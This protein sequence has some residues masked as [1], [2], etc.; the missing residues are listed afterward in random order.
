MLTSHGT[1]RFSRLAV[2]A[3][4]LAGLGLA[5]AAALA[6]GAMEKPLSRIYMCYKEDPEKL[7]GSYDGVP[8]GSPPCID[9]VKMSGTQPLYDWTEVNRFD[10]DGDHK[11]VAPDGQLCSAGRD[12][13]KGLDQRRSDWPTTKIKPDAKGKFTFRFHATTPHAVKYFRFYVTRDGWKP[14][15]ELR[16]RDLE[17]FATVKNV[18]AESDPTQSYGQYYNMTVKMPEN[19][20]GR[21]L[22]FAVWQRSDSPEAFYSCSDVRIQSA[23]SATSAAAD[24]VSWDEAGRAVARND[25]PAGSTVTF[26]VFDAKGGDVDRITVKLTDETGTAEAWP[27]ALAKKVNAATE[28]F[29]IGVEDDDA[30]IAPEKSASENRVY[31]SSR[32]DGYSYA[33]DV[34][35][36]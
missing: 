2:A 21:R 17:L 11:K 10:A 8:A 28:A 31:R 13:Y 26:R 9:L 24:A 7:R 23:K 33:I 19:R 25:L 4:L 32:F 5:P 22:I 29:R 1:E 18:E 6:H 3:S 15:D 12:K 30:A 16:W 27:F 14:T 20:T 35:T 36:P 34:D